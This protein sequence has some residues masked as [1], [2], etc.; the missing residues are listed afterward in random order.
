MIRYIPVRKF[1]PPLTSIVSVVSVQQQRL[2]LSFLRYPV[3]ASAGNRF[4]SLMFLLFFFGTE[5]KFPSS[6]ACLLQYLNGRSKLR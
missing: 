2:S 6:G 4:S 1:T 5:S 3:R